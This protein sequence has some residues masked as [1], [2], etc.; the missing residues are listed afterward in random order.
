MVAASLAFGLALRLFF[1]CRYAHIEGDGLIYGNLA[2]NLL[3]HGVYGFTDNAM[4]VRPTLIRLP[5]YPLFLAGCFAI[6]GVGKYFAVLLVQVVVDLWTCVLVA[7]V[8]RR[9]FGEQAGIAA[10]WMGCMCPFMATYTAAPLTEVLTLWTIAL[11]LYALAHWRTSGA[12]INRWLFVLAFALGFS[13]LLRP[14]Q[15]LLAA[16]I[17][18][19]V[20]W[21]S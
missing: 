13:L 3:Q 10:L 21:I 6:F 17:V 2:Q 8:S 11:A 15:G 18:P 1:V 14:E 12:G 20:L 5:G 4:G 19:A 9:I 7:G 16:A